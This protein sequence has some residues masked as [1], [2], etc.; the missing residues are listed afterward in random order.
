MTPEERL[1]Q[2]TDLYESS[3]VPFDVDEGF[4]EAIQIARTAIAERDQLRI[5][6][7]GEWEAARYEGFNKGIEDAAAAADYAKRLFLERADLYDEPYLKA[8]LM[9]T[10]AH[11]IRAL[12]TGAQRESI[13]KENQ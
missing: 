10:I 9:K 4:L 3:G 5:E 13:T 1:N 2:L 8:D 11:D 12:A 7:Y 6:V